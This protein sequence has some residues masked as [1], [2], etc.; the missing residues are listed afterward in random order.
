MEA[1]FTVVSSKGQIVIP[2]VLREKLGIKT[3]TRIAI[4][5]EENQL[6]LQP[7][8]AGYIDSLVG[9]CKGKDSLVEAREREHRIEKR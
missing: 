2:A 6:I 8:T 4:H 7:I 1:I 3:G 5:T 9:C